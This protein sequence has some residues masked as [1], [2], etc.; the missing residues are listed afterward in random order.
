MRLNM[1]MLKSAVLLANEHPSEQK[2][3]LPMIFV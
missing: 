2:K 1:E 3:M